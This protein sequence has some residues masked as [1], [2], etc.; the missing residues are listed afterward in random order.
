MKQR[1]AK[2]WRK[3]GENIC[4]EDGKR[5]KRLGRGNGSPSYSSWEGERVRIT[6]SPSESVSS[7]WKEPQPRT[8]VSLQSEAWPLLLRREPRLLLGATSLLSVAKEKKRKTRETFLHSREILSTP[9]R[10]VFSSEGSK[11]SDPE[12]LGSCLASFKKYVCGGI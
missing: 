12:G 1:L 4:Q 8:G 10:Y 7:I 5:C 3:R 6:C 9:A 2:A 11:E